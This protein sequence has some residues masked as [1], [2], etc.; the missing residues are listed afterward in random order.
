MPP[1]LRPN[2]GIYLSLIPQPEE[3]DKNRYKLP[4][5]LRRALKVEIFSPPSL[6]VQAGLNLRVYMDGPTRKL[7]AATRE[8]RRDHEGDRLANLYGYTLD[9]GGAFVGVGVAPD[10]SVEAFPLPKLAQRQFYASLRAVG[11]DIVE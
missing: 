7:K 8:R 1:L 11:V 5:L 9:G 3:D 2:L 10:R 6:A 4:C